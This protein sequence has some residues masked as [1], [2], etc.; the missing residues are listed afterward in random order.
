MSTRLPPRPD[1]VDDVTRRELI[2]AAMAAGLLATAG[3][4]SPTERQGA[5]TGSGDGWR[6]T[7]DR[8]VEVRLSAR[9]QRIAAY[10]APGAALLSLGVPV[11]ALFGGPKAG[12]SLLDGVD[13]TGV[14]SAGEVYGE[15]N[16]EKLAALGVDLVVTAYDPLQK[17]PVFGFVAGPG[18]EQVERVAPIVA[19]D[20]IRSPA[21]V[22]GRFEALAT[23]LGADIQT[24]AVAGARRRF[25]QAREALR[26][27]VAAKP[28]LLAAGIYATPSDGITFQRPGASPASRQ[29]VELGLP[30]VEPRSEG[31]DINEDFSG[32][33]GEAASLE[34]ADRYPADLILVIQGTELD[35][36]AQVATWAALPAVRANQIGRYSTLVHWTYDQ[37]ANELE[38]IT[39]VVRAANPDLV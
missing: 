7:D 20:G 34:E 10:D 31:S 25:E 3:C 9:P 32:F 4:G 12:N 14:A 1:V 33:F 22:I 38:A 13:L 23:S 2:L 17:G 37:Q 28:G 36:M 21:E 26:S 29:L 11:V 30:L 39:A 35:A 15:V 8:G 19:I 27:A 5:N 24:P 18:Q 16:V 6:F